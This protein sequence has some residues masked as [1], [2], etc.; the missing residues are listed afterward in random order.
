MLDNIINGFSE[1]TVD[2]SEIPHN[3]A[4][5]DHYLIQLDENSV[6]SDEISMSEYFKKQSNYIMYKVK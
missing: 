6:L 4:T 3:R 1:V 2:C 5:K